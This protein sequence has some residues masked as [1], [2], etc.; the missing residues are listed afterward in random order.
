M[1]SIFSLVSGDRHKLSK[2]R[3]PCW[4]AVPISTVNGGAVR[5]G[6][7]ACRK[8]LLLLRVR[9]ILRCAY[10][11]A[12]VRMQ[13]REYIHILIN[14]VIT[15]KYNSNYVVEINGDSR[16]FSQKIEHA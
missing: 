10:V 7:I 8:Q 5:L 4:Q 12:V 2:Y 16:G 15:L 9:S 11:P 3:Y 6:L 14:G 1:E 13:A